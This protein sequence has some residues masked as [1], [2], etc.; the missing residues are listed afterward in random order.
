MG[1]PRGKSVHPQ[2]READQ[3]GGLQRPSHPEVHPQGRSLRPRRPLLR[4]DEDYGRQRHR[5]GGHRPRLQ[6]Q[7]PAFI[8]KDQNN[9]NIFLFRPSAADL[10]PRSTTSLPRTSCRPTLSRRFRREA[11]SS[12][13]SPG[14]PPPARPSPSSSVAPTS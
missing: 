11:A 5:E 1:S 6:G 8:N 4:Q 3:E 10:S 14:S 12:S 13:R 7:H 2:H 9:F